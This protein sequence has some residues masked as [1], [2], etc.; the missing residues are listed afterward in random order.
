MKNLRTE[1]TEF[2]IT[3]NTSFVLIK[4]DLIQSSLIV[5]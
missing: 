2:T 5:K 4:D 1:S 3:R